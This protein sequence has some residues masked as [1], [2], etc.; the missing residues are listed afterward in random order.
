MVQGSAPVLMMKNAMPHGVW[1]EKS[2]MALASI[3]EAVGRFPVT[4]SADAWL[5]IGVK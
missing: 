3:E 5:G 2:A 4:L 1:Q